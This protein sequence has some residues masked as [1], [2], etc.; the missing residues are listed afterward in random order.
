M[1]SWGSL[2]PSALVRIGWMV[3][4]SSRL[5]QNVCLINLSADHYIFC[6]SKTAVDLPLEKLKMHM[7][8]WEQM[9]RCRLL[10]R[11]WYED[12]DGLLQIETKPT[13]V[14][15]SR[16]CSQET[17]PSQCS[18]PVS[19]PANDNSCGKPQ[20]RQSFVI[21]WILWTPG[22]RTQFLPADNERGN[23]NYLA[24]RSGFRFHTEIFFQNLQLSVCGRFSIII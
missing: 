21:R 17:C 22:R 23:N 7:T 10:V 19:G 13:L 1:Q 11:W 2:I 20:I 24:V 16:D 18:A 9:T 8:G 3:Q 6:F 5:Y 4:H 14:D 12:A 15:N